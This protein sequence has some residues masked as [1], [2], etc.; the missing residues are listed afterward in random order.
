MNNTYKGAGVDIE[1]GD[2]A[3][4]LMKESIQRTLSPNVLGGFGGFAGMYDLSF[5]KDMVRPILTTST[6]GVGTKVALAIAMDKHDTIG[7]DLVGMVVDDIVVSG[8]KPLFMTD[9]I[10]AGRVVP[11]KIASLVGGIADACE[12]AGVS[13]IAGETAEHPG[14]MEPDE[15]DVAGAAVGIVDAKDLLVPENVRAGDK[16]VALASSGLHSNGYSLVRKVFADA[17]WSYDKVLDDFSGQQLGEVLLTPTRIYTELCLE[18]AARTTIHAFSHITGGGIAVNLARVLPTNLV[19]IVERN[20]WNIP[21]IFNL[22]QEV[23][24][25]ETTT[26]EQTLNMGIGML[27]ILPENQV[28]KVIEICQTSA[29]HAWECG[30]IE[31]VRYSTITLKP[32]S[33][34]RNTKGVQGGGAILV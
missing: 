28:A 4:E 25:V 33:V 17:K 23:G 5:A 8:S 9:Y 6:D 18:L 7:H 15:Y 30:R 21:P 32:G 10:C 27:A 11:E 14:L 1:A 31:E 22:V 3:V 20:T 34:V 12:L 24:K 29:V 26:M 2:K 19:G 13:L 16:I